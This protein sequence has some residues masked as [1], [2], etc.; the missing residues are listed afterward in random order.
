ML[1]KFFSRLHKQSR[2]D[3]IPESKPEPQLKQVPETHL[4]DA[5]SEIRK[6]AEKASRPSPSLSKRLNSYTPGKPRTIIIDFE[7]TGLSPKCGDRVIEIGA[8]AIEEGRI[9]DRYQSLVNPGFRISSFIEE[10]TGIT[11]SMVSNAPSPERVFHEFADFLGG[12]PLVAHNASFDRRFL[13]H[14]MSLIRREIFQGIACSMLVARRVYPELKSHKLE[15]LVQSQSLPSEGVH[16]RA[17]ADA[18][19]TAHLWMR[20]TE[21]LMR[22]YFL[23]EVPFDLLV[24]LSRIPKNKVAN[25][26]KEYSKNGFSS[27]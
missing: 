21:D 27:R 3:D 20:M 13:L 22:E 18:E 5:R 16:H 26:L 10:Y 15:S 19:M 11:N 6:A 12:F 4:P 1:K 8:V 9:V 17:L 25:H 14:E 7:T 24:Q 23:S 2:S